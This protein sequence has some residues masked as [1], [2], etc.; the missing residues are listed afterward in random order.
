MKD[1]IRNKLRSTFDPR[2]TDDKENI[3]GLHTLIHISRTDPAF[4]RK[5]LGEYGYLT[6]AF[7][8]PNAIGLPV[9]FDHLGVF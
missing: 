2:R 4:Y 9:G 8:D 5:I 6:Y 3:L 1:V 7:K